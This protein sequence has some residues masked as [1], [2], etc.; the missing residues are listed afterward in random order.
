MPIQN[1]GEA[2]AH[3]LIKFILENPDKTLKELFLLGLE[4]IFG[5]TLGRWI[6]IASIY[7]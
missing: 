3:F 6:K 1:W 2:M 4:K 5:W 7:I